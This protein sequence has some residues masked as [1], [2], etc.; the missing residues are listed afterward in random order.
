GALLHEIVTMTRRHQGSTPMEILDNAYISAPVAY[1]G[2]VPVELAA[3]CNR[4]TARDPEARFQSA[5]EFRLAVAG[6]LQHRTSAALLES[7]RDQL[8]K[9][10]VVGNTDEAPRQTAVQRLFYECDFALRKSSEA[11]P[12][13]PGI[14]PL[15]AQLARARVA[16]ALALRH[17]DEAADYLDELDETASDLR[18]G[19]TDLRDSLA[20]EARL[21]HLGKGFD[22]RVGVYARAGVVYAI[23]LLWFIPCLLLEVGTRLGWF[24]LSKRVIVTSAF[25]GNVVL[26]LVLLR[27]GGVFWRS[28]TNRRLLGLYF[29][30]AFVAVVLWFALLDTLSLEALMLMSLVLCFLFLGAT[31]IAFDPRLSVT[32]IPVAIGCMA[33]SVWPSWCMLITGLA[34]GGAGM[35]SAWITSRAAQSVRRPRR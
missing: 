20:H 24:A 34:A 7:A 11:W 22:P 15:R 6:F 5:E 8:A 10:E 9:L 26:S 27:F 35:L 1:S 14:A 30:F 3:I 23:G 12:E 29:F 32:L 19:L 33:L 25:A 21:Q 13:N 4:A 31:T 18:K 28:L 17:V 2:D 16:H